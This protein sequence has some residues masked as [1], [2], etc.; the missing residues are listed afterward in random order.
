M[1]ASQVTMSHFQGLGIVLTLIGVFSYT[2]L[3]L[4]VSQFIYPPPHCFNS[5]IR[6]YTYRVFIEPD[7][8]PSLQENAPKPAPL[9]GVRTDDGS[10]A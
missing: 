9:Q 1:T 6:P 5:H 7:E 8:L 3:K 10:K 4:Q 2:H